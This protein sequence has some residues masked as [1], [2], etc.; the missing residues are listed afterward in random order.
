M[1]VITT[2]KLLNNVKFL[3]KCIVIN[4]EG[5]IL[6]LLRPPDDPRRPNCWDFPG[7]NLEQGET[8]DSCMKREIKEE[9]GLTARV[10]HPVYLADNMGQTHQEITVIAVCQMCTDWGGELQ[11][12]K[13][14]TEYRWVKPDE[15]FKLE[16]GDDGNFLKDSLR[17]YLSLRGDSS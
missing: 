8:I 7:G 11:L 17:A 1:Q 5:K 16:T 15:F 9:T 4:G 14:H 10:V 13:E 3:Q 6:A 12:S 2:P